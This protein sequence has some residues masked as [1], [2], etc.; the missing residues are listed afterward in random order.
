MSPTRV[1]FSELSFT[2]AHITILEIESFCYKDHRTM[3]I[4]SQLTVSTQLPKELQQRF[5]SLGAQTMVIIVHRT[6]ANDTDDATRVHVFVPTQSTQYSVQQM[7]VG[8]YPRQRHNKAYRCMCV[9]SCSHTQPTQWNTR[10][11]SAARK[12]SAASW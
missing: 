9:R 7:H 4:D 1:N 10:T 5:P 3:R 6:Y 12:C 2:L 11:L 8:T